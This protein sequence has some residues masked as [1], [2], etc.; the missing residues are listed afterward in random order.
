[1]Y[2][3]AGL[4]V[5][6]P[7]A[8]ASATG[9]IFASTS[10]A[11]TTIAMRYMPMIVKRIERR[12]WRI[13][14]VVIAAASVGTIMSGPKNTDTIPI[15]IAVDAENIACECAVERFRTCAI[16]LMTIEIAKNTRPTNTSHHERTPRP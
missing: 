7:P 10:S 12:V 8:D 13:D 5:R 14:E 9:C 2:T 15:P 3:A 11:G 4:V 6:R 16:R 1:M